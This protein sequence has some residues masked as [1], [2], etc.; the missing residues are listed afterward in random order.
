MDRVTAIIILTDRSV[1]FS[2]V[3]PC[4][5]NCASVVLTEVIAAP[6]HSSHGAPVMPTAV[7]NNARETSLSKLKW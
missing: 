3:V 6:L 5:P 1:L 7:A 4:G 2:A